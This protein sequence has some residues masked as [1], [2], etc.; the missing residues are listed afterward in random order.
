M[1]DAV[2]EKQEDMLR[3]LKSKF[4]S[5]SSSL[6]K[7]VYDFLGQMTR[8]VT[9]NKD[10]INTVLSSLKN[11]KLIQLRSR[12]EF[13][14]PFAA[15]EALANL[16][17]LQY[18]GEGNDPDIRTKVDG[19]IVALQGTP[20]E[21]L[22]RVEKILLTLASVPDAFGLFHDRVHRDPGGARPAKVTDRRSKK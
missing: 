14:V 13:R 4:G 18:Y 17:L 20:Q 1:E 21:R 6:E 22:S 10:K 2:H 5:A 9:G 15:V 7:N 19:F 12:E 8:A 11:T 3:I 16:A